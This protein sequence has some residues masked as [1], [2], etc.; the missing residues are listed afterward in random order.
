MHVRKLVCAATLA[1]AASTLGFRDA[2]G[3]GAGNQGPAPGSPPA[4][5]SAVS[6]FSA[7]DV[8]GKE[9]SLAQI[10]RNKV[11]VL[12][13]LGAECPLVK[14][15][16]PRLVEL[17]GKYEPQGV[18][19]LGISSNRQDSIAGLAAFVRT[20]RI[21]FPV[22]K[23]LK[24]RIADSVGAVRT[25]EVV[26]LDRERRLRYRGRI[27]DQFGFVPSNKTASYHR[28][29][30][31]R[32]DLATALDE[33]IAGHAVSRVETEVAGCLIGR[34][35]AVNP[36]GAVTYSKQ[37]ARLLNQRCVVCHRS[38][39]I[40]PFSLTNYDEAAGWADMIDEVVQ[41]GRMPPWHAD[42][43]IGRFHNDVHL[44]DAE[45]HLISEWAANGAPQGDLKEL[46]EPPK[47]ADG[48]MIPQPDEVLYMSAKPY[49]V[50]ATGVVEY[51]MFV[52]DTG[53]KE[54]R[55]ISAIEPRP[56]NPAVVHH[57]LLLVLPPDGTFQGLGG[58]DDFLGAYAPGLRPEPLPTGMARRVKAGSK[59]IFQ[60]HY[61]PNGSAQK[62]RSSVGIKF[63]EP[64]TVRQEVTVSS[65]I[66]AVF[67][68]P[69][70]AANQEV[71][72]RY[73][74]KRD[75]ILLTLMPHMHLRGKDFTYE[76]VY[77]DG[78]RETLLSVPRYDFGWQTNYRLTEP[79]RMPQGSVLQCVAHFDN[80]ADNLNNPNPRVAVTWG[81]QTF[82]EMMIGFFE[83]IP[84]EQDLT[85]SRQPRRLTRLEQ[86][87]VI[88]RATKGQP[89]DNVQ[90]AAYL[91]LNDQEWMTRFG[92][93]LPLM[94]P[95]VDRVCVTAVEN[96]RVKQVTGP[97]P[98]RSEK[99]DHAPPE[100]LHSPLPESASAAEPL[101]KDIAAGHPVVH[102]D[103]A[104][105]KGPIFEA[106]FRRGARSSLH[107]PVTVHGKKMTVNYWSRDARAFPASAVQLLAALSN[108]MA[109]PHAG[110]K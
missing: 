73:I 78:R 92:Q 12:A 63:V 93:I 48:W 109:A 23:D 27:D 26:V 41:S 51:Q 36:N 53:W 65:A 47:F 21:P 57:I 7:R 77:P 67:Q 105:S 87:D 45:K 29:E 34:D 76:A 64:K 98:P 103:L 19:F 74:F 68:I 38:G 69:A 61:T 102:D 110:A 54:D 42:P 6:S 2:A 46:P 15:Y 89:D 25:P 1:A 84:I 108:A 82:D 86:F 95:Q 99:K 85:K 31:I 75:S 106:M 55:W 8:S 62:D 58:D 9:Q 10:G 40:A 83:A 13:F 90:V 91:A 37:I 72:A 11:V 79:K 39:Q 17:A 43:R 18:A 24:Q 107:V 104:V 22:V 35:R 71:H 16:A 33:I 60:M 44:S 20:H 59:L 50:P 94:V 88:M 96:G 56:G 97:Y 28:P 49:D 70:G 3:Q 66:N 80:S 14:V 100:G 4:I 32:N 101:S 30:A 81:D 52:V 5:G